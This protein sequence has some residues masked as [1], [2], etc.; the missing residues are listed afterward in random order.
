M[1]PLDELEAEP[2]ELNARELESVLEWEGFSPRA[3]RREAEAMVAY[4]EYEHKRDFAPKL[5]A[6]PRR[7]ARP[8]ARVCRSRPRPHARNVVRRGRARS[9]DPDLPLAAAGGEPR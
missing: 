1:L 7:T 2:R 4:R 9:P 5:V 6:P 3:A 8:V